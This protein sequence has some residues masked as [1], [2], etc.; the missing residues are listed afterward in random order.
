[1]PVSADPRRLRPSMSNGL[2]TTATVRMPSSLATCATTGAAPV[3]VPPPMPAVMNSMSEP[4]II[5]MMR[6]R[7]SIA[8]WRPTSG[9]APAP[10]PLVMLQPICRP[11]FTFE[12][13][14]A[15]ASVLM[16][17]KST[18]SIPAEIMCA[19]ALPPPPPTPITL[20]T[21]PWFSVSASTNIVSPLDVCETS[22]AHLQQLCGFACAQR[23]QAAP[24]PFDNNNESSKI[25]LKPCP[26]PV[27]D[28]AHLAERLAAPAAQ[29]VLAAVQQQADARRMNRI[30]DDVD[31]AG[32]VLRNAQPHRHVE[33][34]FGELH[35]A[36]H[37]RAAAGEHHARGDDFL[38][39][40]AAQ[41]FADQREHFLVAR[42]DHFGERLAREPPRR[43]VADARHFDRL[44]GV[45]QLR[46]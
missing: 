6:S 19:T 14:S 30:A 24:Q 12:C 22:S 11:T 17:M 35:G 28:T 5:S 45:R 23:T 41:L 34:L 15:C 39:A 32:D 7:S 27:V 46:Q 20:I 1:M 33:H 9:S 36:F 43:T 31:Q 26:H 4:S 8:A 29:G 40:G 10:S 42:L 13:L 18:P 21:A 38:E 25:A 3:P 44:V 16:Q 2:V 37:L